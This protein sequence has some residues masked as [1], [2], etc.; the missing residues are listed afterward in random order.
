MSSS[1]WQENLFASFARL[2]AKYSIFFFKKSVFKAG[3]VSEEA[4]DLFREATYRDE[5]YLYSLH[6]PCV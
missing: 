2:T 5:K 6:S 3:H 1:K 4:Q